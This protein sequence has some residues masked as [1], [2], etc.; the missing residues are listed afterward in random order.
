MSQELRLD[1]HIVKELDKQY[2]GA[3]VGQAEFFAAGVRKGIQ[4]ADATLL[5]PSDLDPIELAFTVK[6]LLRKPRRIASLI[7]TQGRMNDL[8]SR[9]IWERTKLSG[10]AP[11]TLPSTTT[12]LFE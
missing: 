2:M 3:P 4:A 6:A 8:F 1:W 7:P 5:Y 10:S 11:I 12:V 9:P